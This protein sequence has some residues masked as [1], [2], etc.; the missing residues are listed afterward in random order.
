M[1]HKLTV[2]QVAVVLC[3]LQA[4]LVLLVPVFLDKDFQ[5]VNLLQLRRF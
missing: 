1:L 4:R 3:T 5:V 2:V